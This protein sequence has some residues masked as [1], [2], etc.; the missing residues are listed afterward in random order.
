MGLYILC[1]YY[2]RDR[3]LSI[4]CEDTIRCYPNRKS[5][6]RV[7]YGYC[8]SDWE[9]CPYANRLNTIYALDIPEEI[10]EE[11]KMENTIEEQKTEIN[12]LMRENG[13]L[14][15]KIKKLESN[16]KDREDVAKSN[17]DTYQKSYRELEQARETIKAQDELI[18][19]LN[20]FAS[21]FMVI[22]YGEDTEKVTIPRE[23]IFKL[24]TEYQMWCEE[25]KDDEAGSIVFHF[26]HIK[27]KEE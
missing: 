6:N 2:V 4:S 11:L 17:Y 21:A 7:L 5:K 16:I 23:K 12:K 22:A 25:G 8:A 10:M 14:K 15:K 13:Q 24:Q 9:R 18:K 26:E 3:N 1:P 19:W 20:S 27:D